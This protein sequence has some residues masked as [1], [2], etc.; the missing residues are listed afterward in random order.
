LVVRANGCWSL[1]GGDNFA[2]H[3][4]GVRL[5]RFSFYRD[6]IFVPD[7]QTKIKCELPLLV[8]G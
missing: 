1:V 3:E 4:W 8:V 2:G 7:R 5:V 6:N